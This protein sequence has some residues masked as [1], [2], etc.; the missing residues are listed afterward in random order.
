MN[1][2]LQEMWDSAH[3][4]PLRGFVP[5]GTV[6][7]Q[8]D[9]TGPSGEPELNYYMAHVSEYWQGSPASAPVRSVEFIEDPAD[10]GTFTVH[11]DDGVIVLVDT[12][13][14]R[15]YDLSKNQARNLVR[16]ITEAIDGH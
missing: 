2:K 15:C 13:D 9:P 16:I 8:L 7:V 1:K 5:E 3:G 6:L 4:I 10:T 11:S 12:Y 14:D